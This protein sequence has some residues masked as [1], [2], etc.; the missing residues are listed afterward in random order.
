MVQDWSL[1]P[2]AVTAVLHANEK[3]DTVQM[4][5]GSRPREIGTVA[6]DREAGPRGVLTGRLPTNQGVGMRA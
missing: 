3:E 2:T 6:W 1:G 5:I 4:S